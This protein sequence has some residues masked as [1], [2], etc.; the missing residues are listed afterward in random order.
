MD[1]SLSSWTR[2]LTGEGGKNCVS[3]GPEHFEVIHFYFV[4]TRGHFNAGPTRNLATTYTE[5][6]CDQSP[7]PCAG[8]LYICRWHDGMDNLVFSQCQPILGPASVLVCGP[9]SGHSP[10]KPERP[11]L[12]L[13]VRT[14]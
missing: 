4:T 9:Q 7:V 5:V 13:S 10:I 11:V 8:Y 12:V 14:Y 6:Y 1:G 3:K 2:Y